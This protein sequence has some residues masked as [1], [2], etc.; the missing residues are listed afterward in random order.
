MKEILF[1]KND[2][3]NLEFSLNREIL[4][5][6]MSNA[7]ACTTLAG[8]NTR[9]YH[10]LLIVPQPKI[11]NENHVLLSYL[12]ETVIQNSNAFHLALHRYKDGVYFP[13][14]HKYLDSYY[15]KN[16][17]V[18]TYTIGDIV[19]TKEMQIQ[20]RRDRLLIKYTLEKSSSD[21]TLQ[22]NPLLAFRQVHKLSYRNDNADTGYTKAE[23]GISFKM[24]RNYTPLFIQFS[25]HFEYEHKP[26]WYYD[27][28][29][30]Q[31]KDRGYDYTEDLFM[32]GTFS[33]NLKCGESFYL[34]C[35]IEEGSNPLLLS[36][37]FKRES[38]NRFDINS[39]EDV[40][41][42]AARMFFCRQ[43]MEVNVIAGFPWFGRWGRDTFISLPGLCLGVEDMDLLLVVTD[44]MLK[45]YRDGLFPNLGQGVDAAYNSADTPLW[46]FWCLQQYAAITGDDE[47]V[48]KKYSNVMKSI[49]RTFEQ[50]TKNIRMESNYL[51]WQG[52]DG[53]ALTWMDA[54]IDGNPVTQRKGYAVEINALW[55]NAV[56][57]TRSLAEKYCDDAFLREWDDFATAF[58]TAFKDMFWSKERGYLADCSDGTEKDFS[59]RPNMIFVSSLEYSPLSEKIRQLIIEKVRSELLT[60]KGLQTLSPKDEKFKGYY[61]GN[62]RERDLAYHNGTVWPWL[63]GA[64]CEACLRM[65]GKQ[66]LDF[67][68]KIYKGFE[69]ILCDYCVGSVAEVYDG[70]PPFKA[71]GSI[72]QA[73]S[74]AALIRIKYLL[75]KYS[76][77]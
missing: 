76:Q 30:I 10:G 29:Y 69:D 51:L 26:D 55:Y 19:L 22:L 64:F 11:D 60:P 18:T 28:E 52:E 42:R 13:K 46:F 68:D 3:L 14:G 21:I 49:L 38:S 37:D 34:S 1:K 12:D 57:F 41:K 25:K 45:D 74:V 44:T 7:Y 27:F 35:G 70:N 77:N 53:K 75:D 23:N 43:G 58:P 61:A 2:L 66:A 17:P 56:M 24:Y 39:M 4:R 32:P 16:L 54:V 73:W 20:Q 6:N 40:L 48:W 63:L 33:V 15:L 5:A 31:E 62:Q 9:K 67:V 8:C 50:G 65:Y 59:V 71:G 47:K 72:S 36:S